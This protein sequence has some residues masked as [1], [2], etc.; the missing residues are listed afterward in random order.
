MIINSK[1]RV[2]LL[3]AILIFFPVIVMAT[4][5][6]VDAS[7]GN[8]AHDGK[9]E[10][11]AWKTI[12]KV[13]NATFL[14]P[15][16]SVLFKRS[17]IWRG[18]TLR[19]P[20]SG[21]PNNPIIFSSYGESSAHPQITVSKLIENHQ[22]I[23]ESY[24]EY[25]FS[26]VTNGNIVLLEDRKRIPGISLGNKLP[27]PEVGYLNPGEWAWDGSNKLF[28]KPSSSS[29]S[30]SDHIIELANGW[31]R[32][33]DTYEK[34]YIEIENLELYGAF[35]QVIFISNGTNI[36][37]SNCIIHA[38]ERGLELHHTD[39]VT[40]ENNEV[41]D[42]HRKGI[43]VMDGSTN[44]VVRNN[45]IHDIG[46]LYVDDDDLEGVLIGGGRLQHR[47]SDAIIEGNL[48]EYIGRDWYAGKDGTSSRG[49]MDSAGIEIDAVKNIIIRNNIIKWVWRTGIH[50]QAASAVTDNI[51]IYGNVLYEIGHMTELNWLTSGII[52]SSTQGFPISNISIF[53]NT[54]AKSVFQSDLAQKEGAFKILVYDRPE[55]G[56]FGNEIRGLNFVNNILQSEGDFAISVIIGKASGLVDYFSNNNLISKTQGSGIYWQIDG[57]SPQEY[58]L[59]DVLGDQPGY[60]SYDTSHDTLSI[61]SDP[62]FIDPIT[63]NY[64]LSPSSL[65][66]DAG[67]VIGNRS[68]DLEGNTIIAQPDLGAYEFGSRY[69]PEQERTS[70]GIVDGD[71]T[72]THY[73]DNNYKAIT[74]VPRGPNKSVLTHEWTFQ[75][76][77]N[78]LTT[79]YVNAYKSDSI[80]EE[81]FI[82]EYQIPSLDTSWVSTGLTITNTSDDN[83]YLSYKL[84]PN[85]SGTVVIRVEDSYR[86]KGDTTLDT[87]YVDHLFLRIQ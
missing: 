57:S 64:K 10:S 55:Q 12:N 16:D 41:Y 15:G 24:G 84:P 66:V 62:E 54:I 43:G 61:V 76:P 34:S 45:H 2:Y 3:T 29:G 63:D 18:T 74:E 19:I 32:T 78:N 40:L 68:N 1:V 87:L 86:S 14:A 17:E 73:N 13:N 39:Q 69:F 75:V 22:W 31:K 44:S 11:T 67:I 37:I 38:G 60:Y 23:L 83:N 85:I 80:N 20:A 25:S 59:E 46:R 56:L 47:P 8:D 42:I 35:N 7:H 72:N 70:Q 9:S 79:L 65:S 71:L 81:N 52:V 48:I 49:T 82:F 30:P 6:Y 36:K 58:D 51:N 50:V 53:N 21:E 5:Y 26:P 4:N 28:Y 27:G 33:L 77:E